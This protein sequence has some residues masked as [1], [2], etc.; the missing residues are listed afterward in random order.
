[1]TMQPLNE[2]KVQRS[3]TMHAAFDDARPGVSG[4]RDPP[5]APCKPLKPNL[6]A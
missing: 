2:L 6:S 4:D 1:M 5:R 3:L